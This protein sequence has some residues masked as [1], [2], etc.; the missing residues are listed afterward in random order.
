MTPIPE[1]DRTK[2]IK[3]L[4]RPGL[5]EQYHLFDEE[6]ADAIRAALAA[7]RPLLIRANRAWARPS[8]P[9]RPR[10]CSDAPWYRRWSTPE[11]SRAI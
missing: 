4:D 3:L 5:P 6:S 1:I 7:M 11:Q 10:L 2:P 8:S 9:R